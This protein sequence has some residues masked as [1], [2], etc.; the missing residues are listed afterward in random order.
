V[1]PGGRAEEGASI[2]GDVAFY[3]GACGLCHATVRFVLL[4]DRAGVLTYAPIGGATWR[5]VFPAGSAA[6]PTDTM[7]VRTS[8]LRVLVRSDAVA[9]L[10]SRLPGLWPL[11]GSM[12]R[13]VPR[14]L[15]DAGYRGVASVRRGLFAPPGDVCPVVPRHL[16]GRFLP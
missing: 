3:D 11:A 13:V 15:R 14:P 6:P 8:D 2:V 9:Y 16:R 10:L 1:T 5:E 12:L 7:S 4:R